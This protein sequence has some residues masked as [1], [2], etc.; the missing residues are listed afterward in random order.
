MVEEFIDELEGAC[1]FTKLDLS[2]GYH[3][4]MLAEGEQHKTA[5]Q[6]HHGLYE[7]SVMPFGL[8]NAPTSF[9]SLMN[10]VFA[11]LLR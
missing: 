4:V 11:P 8:T 6:T 7:F 1:W 2:S 9:Q 3:Q 5:F 10:Q